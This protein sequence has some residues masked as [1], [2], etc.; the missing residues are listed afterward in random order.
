MATIGHRIAADKWRGIVNDLPEARAGG[1]N[2]SIKAFTELAEFSAQKFVKQS[3]A[4]ELKQTKLMFIGFNIYQHD[5][6]LFCSL[7]YALVLPAA[8]AQRCISR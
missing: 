8:S 2:F 3:S 1:K 5:F 4:Q 6:C 7:G